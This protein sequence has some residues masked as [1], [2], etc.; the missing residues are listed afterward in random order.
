[1][2]TQQ[3]KALFDT[4]GGYAVLDPMLQGAGRLSL[5]GLLVKRF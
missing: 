4:R 3:L 1:M 2:K 5:D